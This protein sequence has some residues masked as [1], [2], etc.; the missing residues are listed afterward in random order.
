MFEP[1]PKARELLLANISL[2]SRVGEKV[3]LKYVEYG[4]GEG[5]YEAQVGEAAEN[6][7]GAT[8]LAVLL[9]EDAKVER[10][11]AVVPLDSLKFDLPISL[12]KIDTEGFELKVLRGASRLISEHRPYIAVEVG[13]WLDVEFWAWVHET[14]YHVIQAFQDT[15]GIKNYLL[16][17]TSI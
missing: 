1:N 6:N 7:L 4:V 11:I 3:D 2:N 14:G 17:P 12:I 9:R 16:I 8:K 5:A 13:W 15:R 10:R